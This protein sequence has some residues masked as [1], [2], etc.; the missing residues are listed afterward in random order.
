MDKLKNWKVNPDRK[1]L[2]LRG[3]RQVG[4]TYLLKLFGEKFFPNYYYIN[5]EED[6]QACQIFEKNLNTQR[7]LNDI[8]LYLEKVINI[9][10]DLLIFDEIQHCPKVLTSL[11]Y[12]NEKM[13][14]LAICSAGSL[15]GVNMN[16]DSFPVG[17]VSFLDLYP[18]TFEEFLIAIDKQQF[19]DLL[20]NHNY[21]ESLSEIAHAKLW[22]FWKYYLVT[23]GMPEVIKEYIQ[24]QDNLLLA[25]N[26]TR[27]LQKD[28]IDTYMADI[29]KHSGKTNALHI[30]RLWR[31]VPTQLARSLDG[32]AT[33]FK[34]KDPIPGYRGYERL[35]NPISWL[36]NGGLI[37]RKS[38]IKNARIPLSVNI[39]ENRFKLYLMDVG[40]LGTMNKLSPKTLYDFE[41]GRYKGYIAEN[42]VAQELIAS[43]FKTLIC[44]EGRTSEIEFLIEFENQI[45]PIEVKSGHVTKSKSLKIF[46]EKYQPQQSI[47]FSGKNIKISNQRSY[48]PIY[49]TGFFIR[50]LSGFM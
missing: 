3:T 50:N 17:K 13:P 34:F 24:R 18:M 9:K 16:W 4:K 30:D 39:I 33:K 5:F 15:L 2:I 11:K 7:I 40:L 49:A 32:S 12:F 14:E 42:F 36:E 28:L 45:I 48:I 35:A 8:Q 29:S 6:P 1:P 23:G 21:R 22:D 19:V 37:L 38:I 26:I 41:F 20:N 46:E 47:I 25:F 10:T 43:G 44:W 31:N 27:N